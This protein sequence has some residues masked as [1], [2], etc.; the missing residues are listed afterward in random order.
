MRAVKRGRRPRSR[1]PTARGWPTCRMYDGWADL[2]DGYT[3]SLWAAF[4]SPAGAAGG[5]WVRWASPTCCRRWRRC[6][7]RGPGWLGYAAGVAGRV[8]AAR[9]TGGRVWPDA[10]AHPVSVATFGWLVASSLRRPPRRH[11]DRPRPA[12]ARRLSRVGTGSVAGHD[13]A[14][15]CRDVLRPDVPAGP[16]PRDGPP[17]RGRRRRPA[18]GHRGLLLHRRG[19]AWPPPA[20]AVTERLQVGLGILPA[21]ARNPAVTAMEVATLCGARPGAAAAGHR[22]RRAGVDGPD[23]CPDPVAADH[24]GGGAPRRAPAAGR[25]DA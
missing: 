6:A 21:V 7:G 1:W 17:A 19:R 25:R 15:S 20:L 24:A 12:A 10:L 14:R 13:D 2:R 4:G 3:K 18:V 11:A 23:G 5:R 22:A 8:L 9:R 16:R